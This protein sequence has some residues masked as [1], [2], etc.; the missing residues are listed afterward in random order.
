MSRDVV[1][2]RLRIKRVLQNILKVWVDRGRRAGFRSL[3]HHAWRRRE[4][5]RLVAEGLARLLRFRRKLGV[6]EFTRPLLARLRARAP[7]VAR[8]LTP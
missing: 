7:A 4:H 8:E 6:F 2:E 5:R 3:W 1:A